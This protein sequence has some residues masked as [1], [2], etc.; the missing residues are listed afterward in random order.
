MKWRFSDVNVTG[1]ASTQLG[2]TPEGLSEKNFTTLV[3]WWRCCW[4]VG[5]GVTFGMS[6]AMALFTTP[7][8]AQITPDATLGTER[9]VVTPN[10]EIR[11]LPAER[12]DGG[13]VRGA[14]LFHS[15][16]DFNVGNGQRVYFAN[17]TGIENIFS[18]VTGTN[19][20]DILGTLGVD[21]GANLFLL[22]PNGIIFGENARLDIAGSLLASTANSLVFENGLQF[23]ATNPEAPPMLTINV[24]PGLQYG[25]NQPR[26][27]IAN[28]G[29]LGV[30]QDLTLSASNL[31]LQGQMQAGRNLTLQAQDTV[32]VRD[33]AVNPFIASARSQ[34]LVQGNEAVDIFALNHP[35]SGLFSGGD[36][37]LRSPFQVAGDTH[38]WSGG[39][40][41]IE[42][43]DG[44]LGDLFSHYDPIIRSL[45]DVIFNNYA[46]ASLHILAAGSVNIGTIFIDALE[47]GIPGI[48]FIQEMVQLSNGTAISIDGS[49]QPT[50]DIR[51]GVNPSQIG[52]PGITGVNPITDVFVDNSFFPEAPTL[53]NAPTRA[54]I[55]I[56]DISTFFAP[57]SGFIFLTNQYQ[58]NTALSGGD[59]TI[60]GAGLLENGIEATVFNSDG[61]S[62]ILDSRGNIGLDGSF[63]DS[64]SNMGSAGEI[65]LLAAK[66]IALSNG[67]FLKANAGGEGNAGDIFVQAD[68][69]VSLTGTRTSMLSNLTGGAV[70]QGGNI[71]IQAESLLLKDNALLDASTFGE[72]NAGSIAI[73]VED[74]IVLESGSLIFNNVE[75]GAIGDSGGINIE[76][77]SLFLSDNSQIISIAAGQGNAGNIVIQASDLVSLIGKTD[78]LVSDLVTAIGTRI[79]QGGVGASGDVIIKT[80][81]LSLAGAQIS[82]STLGIGD[83]GSVIVE[84]SDSVTLTNSANIFS[85]VDSGAIG[86]GGEIKIDTDS[87][88]ITNRSGLLTIVRRALFGL[89]SGRGNAGD[90]IINVRGDFTFSGIDSDS[91]PLSP[92]ERLLAGRIAS[93]IDTQ[94]IGTAGNI[95]ITAREFSMN[96]GAEIRS[97]LDQGAIGEAGNVDVQVRSLLMSSSADL[98]TFTAGQGSAGN[99][100]VQ[101]TDSI[102]LTGSNTG[103]NSRIAQGGIG[104]GGDINLDAD[105]L[106]LTN[107]AQ[108]LTLVN[109]SVDGLPAGQGNAGNVTINVRNAV[110]LDGV[111]NGL[112]SA[113]L[114]RVDS[115]AVGRGGD[116][117]IQA[118]SFLADNG[119][120]L[121]ASTEGNG[122]SGDIRIHT[123]DSVVVQG[124]N[125]LLNTITF[126]QQDA[127]NLIFNAKDLIVRDGAMVIA[128]T[129]SEGNG[130][131]VI[132]NTSNSVQVIG[133][134]A[135]GQFP[136]GLFTE[137]GGK[138]MA[139]DLTIATQ[140]LLVQDGGRISA[141]TTG[142]GNGG[143]LSV[144]VSEEVQ[145]SGTGGLLVNATA[146][147]IA[148]DLTITT[149]EMSVTDSAEVT[150][151]SPVGQAGNLSITSNSLALNRGILSAVTGMSGAEGGANIT[152]QNLDILLLS[153][154]SL[155][156]ASA[157]AESNGGNVT[158]DST[159]IVATTPTGLEGSDIIANAF[160]GNGGRIS[161]TTDGLFGIE[162][163]PQRTP[164]NDITVSSQFGLDGEFIEN[165]PGID[166]SRGLAQLPSNLVDAA[167]LIDRSCSPG[168]AATRS[169][170]TITG[171]GGLPPN[172]LEPLDTDAIV[173][174]W[175]SLDSEEENTA[176]TEE[177]TPSSSTP[178]QIVEAQ[179]W[180]V[181]EQ[182]QILLITNAPKVAPQGQG[183]PIAECKAP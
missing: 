34:L 118:Q 49:K 161:V 81:S 141:A 25:S 156:S 133:I 149:N 11:G 29:N 158:I 108:L 127:G 171:R 109:Q 75:S 15:F 42:R 8:L 155:I 166:P 85:A 95:R 63:I 58:P 177:I 82:A 80:S 4:Q 35:D 3:S 110:V 180:V 59:I 138:G 62:V 144:N 132:V 71:E 61:S 107:G 55:T 16:R 168:G 181:N 50:L 22:N 86:N 114:S 98:S 112:P 137:T 1:A 27:T 152:L 116:I 145:L 37:V 182:G 68:G 126:G 23:S 20:S 90:I 97:T 52:V 67:A 24:T 131:D 44:S 46:G 19:S 150:V 36:M 91:N 167:G 64:S 77:R 125:T 162:F 14:N 18:R 84:T 47:T 163:R 170:F 139:G 164:N 151:S 39:S 56:G 104:N 9:S 178:K 101:A 99:V 70:G 26:A 129:F 76:A 154:E 123:Q 183:F 128:S 53:T 135:D 78:N 65:T 175:V 172:P 69:T 7:A 179:G 146:G 136:R 21:G 2:K 115:D 17:P 93:A 100:F 89:P 40:F 130:G 120:A 174:D 106:L 54:D 12:I 48:D 10:V 122:R 30:G 72:G 51:A 6:G 105:S 134:S 117:Y 32:Q 102:S 88:S 83:A 60:T 169:S 28:S 66:D 143:T 43:L 73:K 165:T 96:N 92:L 142:T 31:D 176:P 148:G 124:D 113:I 41:R 5:I 147:G 121:D 87:L 94:V 160:E 13:A 33:S 159:L 119:A 140:H 157:L 153:N 57:T 45:G 103:I 38:Y 173:S 79:E 74:A 111:E